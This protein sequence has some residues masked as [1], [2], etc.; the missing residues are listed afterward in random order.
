M[1]SQAENPSGKRSRGDDAVSRKRRKKIHR[2]E[3]EDLDLEAGLNKAFQHMNSQLL[4]DHMA[5]KTA[6]LAKDLSSV[7]LSDLYIPGTLMACARDRRED[8][9]WCRGPD[10]LFCSLH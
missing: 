3:N 9:S 8:V 6:R 7:E 4:A 2:D 10:V 5:Q 1:S